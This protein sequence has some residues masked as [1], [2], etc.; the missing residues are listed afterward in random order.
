MAISNPAASALPDEL[1]RE[2]F[3]YVTTTGRVSGRPHEVEMWFAAA[4][5]GMTIYLLSGG[6][7][8]SDWVRNIV[9]WPEVRVRIGGQAFAGTGELIE[10]TDE[11]LPARQQVVAKYYGWT[12]GP[13]PNGWARE[14]LPVA[15]RLTP[16]AKPSGRA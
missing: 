10:G 6:R 1:A 3:C 15:I 13:L 12:G 9:R 14:S 16:L 7:D 4:A 11:E 5:E 2:P 8:R